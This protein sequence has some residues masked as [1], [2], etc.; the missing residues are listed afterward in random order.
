MHLLGSMFLRVLCVEIRLHF[1]RYILS[2]YKYAVHIV[3]HALFSVI[4]LTLGDWLL[5][6]PGVRFSLA[7]SAYGWRSAVV[8]LRYDWSAYSG[9][10]EVPGSRCLA[11][12]DTAASASQADSRK[13]T[14]P[15]RT[16]GGVEG[17]TRIKCY[18]HRGMMSVRAF[19]T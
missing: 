14:E 5:R 3:R 7:P 6:F 4:L 18:N 13:A 15:V 17:L 8:S 10:N 12:V 19:S 11:C 9:R 1:T 2:M 16:V